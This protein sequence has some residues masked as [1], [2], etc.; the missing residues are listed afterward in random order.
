V[1]RIAIAGCAAV[2]AALALATPAHAATPEN[3][4]RVER[5][6]VISLPDVEWSD[7]EDGRLPNLKRLFAD[8][9]I[10]ALVTNGVVRPSPIGNSYMTLGAGTRAVATGET[11]GQGFGVDEDFGR[12]P[13]GDVF[14]T[15]TGTAPG[16]GLVY[17]PINNAIDDND[18]ELFGAEVGLLADQLRDAGVGRAVVANADGTDPS[19][20]EDRVPPYRRSAVAA[21]MTSDGKVPGGRVDRELLERA[22]EAPFGLR[23]DPEAVLDTFR[24][25]WRGRSVVLVEASDLLRADLAARFASDDQ[26]VKIRARAL[27]RTDALVGRLLEE[28]DADRDAVIVVG[29]SSPDERPSL[30][31]ASVRAPGFEPGLLRSST[32]RHDGFVNMVDVAPTILR[33]L[34]LDRPEAMEGRKMATGEPAGSLASRMERLVHANEDGLFRDGHVGASMTTVLVLACVLAVLIALVDWL[35]AR[36]V[37]RAWWGGGAWLGAFLAFALIGFL[38]ATYLAVPVHFARNGGA[39]AYWAFVVG[40]ALL[41]AI[42]FSVVGR[43][44][45]VRGVLVALGSVVVLHVVDLVTGAHLEWNSVFGYSPTIGIRL[46][47]EGNMT[48]AQLSTATLL[49]AG[50]LAW[51]VPTRAGKRTAV[52]LLA[53]VIVVMG[54]PIWGND[55]GAVVSALP[56]FAVLAWM[57]LGHEVRARTV[58]AITGIAVAAVIAVGLLD[59][60]RPAD[61]RTHV[62]RFLQKIGT[63][64]DGAVLVVQRKASANLRVFGHSV[65]LGVIIVLVL[66]VAYLWYVAPRSLR[67]LSARITTTRPTV[68]GFLVLAV[69]G[70]A[71][72]DSG[73]AIPG[74]MCAVFQSALVVL[75]AW[76]YF[77]D[78][79][80]ERA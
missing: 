48:F 34:G 38:D 63:D 72:N 21:L 69:L 56:G 32:T 66:L 71:L 62:G 15:R 60:L 35:R 36:G 23:F 7:I 75:M 70:F 43:R 47:G 5:V 54:V 26:R 44:N 51:R 12:D 45:L 17:M 55:F 1:R 77:G 59:L 9:A 11:A 29:P 20:P 61:Q 74:M 27:R 49:F 18:S 19:V 33:L 4:S 41:L 37:R 8:S 22:P 46:V 40:V 6:L 10:G 73:I 67:P 39:V 58:A 52:G 14:R 2:L 42:V 80:P 16:D 53:A 30:T 68:L 25:S 31:P 64:F 78:V 50:L 76:S 65:L 57:L 13:A 24:A 3:A 79:H 28:V